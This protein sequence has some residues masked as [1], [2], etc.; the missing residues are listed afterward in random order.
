MWTVNFL[1]FKL[2]LEKAEEPEIKFQ[3]PLEF[4]LWFL[5]LPRLLWP[6]SGQ[7]PLH[8]S[9]RSGKGKNKSTEHATSTE[10]LVTASPCECCKPRVPYCS[11]IW[12]GAD[13]ISIERMCTV[14]LMCL[15]HPKTV[16]PT[17]SVENLS[18]AEPAPGAKEAGDRCSK[19]LDGRDYVWSI[20]K[21]FFPGV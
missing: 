5:C 9:L 1:M 8:P 12:D 2:V 11:T 18:S 10:S 17:L 19:P 16:L 7:G 6:F 21:N 14:S 15:N 20:K 13:I 4:D 3:H